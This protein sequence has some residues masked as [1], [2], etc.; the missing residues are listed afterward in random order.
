MFER[1]FY[2][3]ELDKKNRYWSIEIYGY[4]INANFKRNK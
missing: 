3:S 4:E 1:G 2:G